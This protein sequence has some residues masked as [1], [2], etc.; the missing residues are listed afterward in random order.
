MA[1]ACLETGVPGRW[2]YD[3][4]YTIAL[5]VFSPGTASREGAMDQTPA[6][7]RGSA[8]C[9]RSIIAARAASVVCLRDD[10]VR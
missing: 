8:V 3:R 6:D 7:K 9:S 4:P 5:P 2:A 10:A 1:P